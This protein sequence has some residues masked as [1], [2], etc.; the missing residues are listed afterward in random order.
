MTAAVLP[1]PRALRLRGLTWLVWRQNRTAFRI[2]LVVALLIAGYAAVR[3]QQIVAAVDQQHLAACRGTSV[4]STECFKKILKFGSAYQFP[5]RRPLQAMVFLPL[6]FG[7]F[8]GGP[9]LAQEL[10]SGTYRTAC[11]QSVTRVR[12]FV[13]KLAV[14]VAMTVIVSGTVALAMTWWWHPAAEVMGGQ[15]PWYEWYPFNGIGPVVVGQSV[16]MLLLGVTFGLLLRR[17]LAAMGA[18]LAVGA[19]VLAGLDRIRGHLLPTV[20]ANAQHTTVPPAPDN[21]WVV[22]DGPLTPSG[23]RTGDVMGCYSAS[24]Y[25]ACMAGHGRTGH[26]AEFH[27]ASQLWPLQWAETGLCLL[28][29]AALAA[30]CVWRVRRQLV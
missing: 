30:L 24:D 19:G 22:A 5:M 25:N 7:L 9:Q 14:P 17:T 4:S 6:L 8:L 11:S 29:A 3:H 27:P 15:F 12:W 13:A 20:S 1:R 2:G 21:A 26:W 18:T 10:E 23:A 28:L 16:L